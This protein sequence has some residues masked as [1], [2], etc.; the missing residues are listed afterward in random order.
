MKSVVDAYSIVYLSASF[1]FFILALFYFI[2]CLLFFEE[3]LRILKGTVT[4]KTVL[5]ISL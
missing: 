2:F 3:N 4:R 1:G 5:I